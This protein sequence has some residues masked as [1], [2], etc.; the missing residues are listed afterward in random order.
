M[1]T[2]LVGQGRMG[3]MGQ[4]NTGMGLDWSHI[5]VCAGNN[6]TILQVGFI[7]IDTGSFMFI[8]GRKKLHICCVQVKNKS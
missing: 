5:R 4:F 3:H 6:P 7:L 1:L 2:I 8:I